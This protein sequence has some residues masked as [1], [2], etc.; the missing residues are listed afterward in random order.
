MLSIAEIR[1]RLADRRLT[2]VAER[3]GLSYPTVKRVADGEEGITLATLRKLSAYFTTPA[4][5][6]DG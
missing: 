4:V 5:S 2:I 1:D 6:S 3:S